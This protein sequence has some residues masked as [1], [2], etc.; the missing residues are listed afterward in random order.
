ML[1]RKH[2][3]LGGDAVQSRVDICQ[4]ALLECGIAPELDPARR[5][6]RARDL[7]ETFAGQR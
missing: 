2:G 6:V 1:W 5:A 4:H 3:A 7:F